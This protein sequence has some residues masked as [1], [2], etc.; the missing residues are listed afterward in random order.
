M[1]TARR[2]GLICLSVICFVLLVARYTRP[3][4]I[5]PSVQIDKEEIFEPAAP[6][7]VSHPAVQQTKAIPVAVKAPSKVAT[8]ATARISIARTM[9]LINSVRNFL[10]TKKTAGYGYSKV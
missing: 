2:T 8:P 9:D 4:R 3:T 10:W 7:E 6:A 1:M 5:A